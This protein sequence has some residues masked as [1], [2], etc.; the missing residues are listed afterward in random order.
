V[1]GE[2]LPALILRVKGERTFRELRGQALR[3]G[4]D[5]PESSWQQ[6]AKPEFKRTKLPDPETIRAFAIGLGVTETEVLLA[7]GRSL[8]LAVGLDNDADL[9]LPGAGVLSAADK[10]VLASMAALL[11]SKMER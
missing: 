11:V 2:T 1:S 6:W 4:H 7:A 9:L 8:G 5:V 10:N 3:F